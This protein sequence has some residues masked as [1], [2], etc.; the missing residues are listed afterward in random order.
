MAID[1]YKPRGKTKASEPGAG[2]AAV[3]PVPIIGIV[4]DN[5]DN[6][7]QGTIRIYPSDNL[8]KDATNSDNWLYCKRLAQFAGQTEATSAEDDFG[9]YAGNPSA[10][11]QWNAPPDKGTKVICIFVNGDPNYGFYI[12][13]SPE[14]DTLSMIPAIGS[15]EN[16]ILNSGEADS[17]GGAVAL[18]ATTIN[19]NNPEIADSP[20]FLTNAKPVHS[21][22]A[23]IM[24]QQGVIRDKYRGPISTSATR[25]ATSRVGWGVSTPG[26]PVYQGGLTD[27]DFASRLGE[28]PE[29]YKI[30]TRRGGHSLVMDDGD[31][32]GKDQLIRLRTA[33]GHQILMSDDGQMLSILHSNG[34]SYIELGKEGTVDVFA[35]NS[36]NIRTQGDLNLHADETLNLNGKNVNINSS[37]NMTFNADNSFSQRVG[38]NYKLYALKNIEIK[39][40]AALGVEAVGQVGIKSS[41]ELFNEGSKINLNSGIASLKP[42]AVD[43]IKVVEH[44]ETL[45]DS[46]K[47]WATAPVKLSSIVSRAPAHMPW[48]AGNQGTDNKNNPDADANLPPA[49][50]ENIATLNAG[51]A[52]GS[53]GGDTPAQNPVAAAGFELGAVSDSID[54]N[55]TTS[56]IAGAAGKASSAFG[57]ASKAGSLTNVVAGVATTATSL[58]VG[59]FGQTPS[60]MTSG[61]L[62]KPG[63][64]TM[65]NTLLNANSGNIASTA[66]TLG[67]TGSP[68]VTADALSSVM[69]QSA[70]TGVSGVNSASKLIN[71][72]TAQAQGV[73]QTLQKGQSALQTMGA[74]TGKEA[75]GGLGAVVS[76][77]LTNTAN[78]GK[79]GES[80]STVSSLI[81][82]ASDISSGSLTDNLGGGASDVLN[83]MKTG[84]TSIVD[85][86]LAGAVGGITSALDTLSSGLELP[87][88]GIDLNIG[89]SAS[90]FKSIINSFPKLEVGVPQ[91][92][93][94]IAGA[95][96]AKVA[97]ASAGMSASDLA[98]PSTISDA[99]A[100]TV[101]AG[102]TEGLFSGATSAVTGGVQGIVDKASAS[103]AG[104]ISDAVSSVDSVGGSVT[105]LTQKGTLQAAANKVQTGA[106]SMVSSAIASGVSQLPG[107]QKLSASV[108]NNAVNAV[109]PIAD[110]LGPVTNALSGVAAKAFSGSDIGDSI[111]AGTSALGGISDFGSITDSVTGAIDSAKNALSGSLSPGAAAA[112]KSAL[113]SLTAGGGSTIS[114]PVVAFNTYDRSSL[115]SLISNVL[116]N[117]IIPRPNLLG[118]ISPEALGALAALKG[119]KK[120]LTTD[121]N[122]LNTLSN[123]VAK[124]Q[125]ALFEAESLYP[126]GS[127][128]IAAAQAAYSSAVTSPA[129]INLTA[130]VKSAQEGFRDIS[131][132]KSALPSETTNPFSSIESAIKE[133]SSNEANKTKNITSSSIDEQ[134][135]ERQ[136]N[137]PVVEGEF[138]GTYAS[139]NCDPT[140]Y[141]ANTYTN[142]IATIEK[143]Q[144]PQ[145]DIVIPEENI[146]DDGA[147]VI[148]NTIDSIIGE[149]T[150]GAGGIG[151]DVAMGEGSYNVGMQNYYIG[152]GSYGYGQGNGVW[153]W[154]QMS[155]TWKLR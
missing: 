70:F 14:T 32:I 116:G 108:V 113:S 96:A 112:L 40:D 38:E 86:Q 139:D 46:V 141:T 80:A 8:D 4:V 110:G 59:A 62:L 135:F 43:P 132:P 37:E 100:S 105:S 2:V 9:E 91:D 88:V 7:H 42:G 79:L 104:A 3:Y 71:S 45:F 115:T 140:L 125:K 5:I 93:N 26:R 11:G 109:N 149:P 28:S 155:V 64:D 114:L 117:P 13:T 39:A 51:L 92:L 12:G 55:V 95:A 129:Y 20:N 133:A 54:K 150:D 30:I 50:A 65:V 56:I 17:Y 67:G 19:T 44:P 106:T 84:A 52:D 136:T 111:A 118:E 29:N 138:G 27:A 147:P 78:A 137:D 85:S 23:S 107:G 33:L 154:D 18:P 124:K 53:L 102:S 89:A 16:V 90:A 25:E 83:S 151:Q 130:K 77:T 76:G 74:V 34:Q 97:G 142:I 41:A 134:G 120:E 119:L 6:N 21:Y 61:G 99:L 131:I 72:S 153:T 127:P 35:T 66:V 122:A 146:V 24:Q 123:N 81:N 69:P 15:A 87:G 60:Q 148:E 103:A 152:Q 73:V 22:S 82:K 63:A 48:S 49:P 75:P 128:E 94:A 98:D 145:P 143:T 57:L 144:V 1:V 121:I 31:I 68:T 10:Y 101:G 47:G 58:V 126:A 36:V